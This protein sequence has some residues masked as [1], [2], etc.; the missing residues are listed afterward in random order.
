[1]SRMKE[2]FMAQRERERDMRRRMGDEEYREWLIAYSKGLNKKQPPQ[3]G[4]QTK[5]K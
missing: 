3:E 4:A 1:M 5:N 2:A